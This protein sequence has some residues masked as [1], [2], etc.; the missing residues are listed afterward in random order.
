MCRAIK[1]LHNFTPPVT[2]DEIRAAA[3]QFVRKVSGFTRPSVAN[4]EAFAA[5]VEEVAGATRRLMEGLVTSAP[6]KTREAEMNRLRERWQKRMR[7][8]ASP[9]R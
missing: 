4:T 3:T 5:A 2:D 1:T 8:P 9:P 6:P 7:P